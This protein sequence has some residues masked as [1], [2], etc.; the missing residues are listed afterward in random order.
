MLEM[1]RRSNNIAGPSVSVVIPTRGGPYLR[2][3]VESVIAQTKPAF[4]I[5]VVVDGAESRAHEV[6]ERLAQLGREVRTVRSRGRGANGARQTGV[7][8][9]GGSHIAFLDDDDLWVDSKLQTQC[10]L[11]DRLQLEGPMLLAGKVALF[12][13][14]GTT[15][16]FWPARAPNSREQIADYLFSHPES[17][18]ANNLQTSTWLANK[19][20]F[21]S[22]PFDDSVGLHQ[23][24]DWLVRNIR[25]DGIGLAYSKTL[26]AHY[27]IGQGSSLSAQGRLS[28]S[29]AWGCDRSIPFSKR[30]RGDFLTFRVTR[31]AFELGDWRMILRALS[32]GLRLG[33]PSFRSVLAALYRLIRLLVARRSR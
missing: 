5:L 7:Y 28:S 25:T 22:C 17:G 14:T 2:E 24:W 15:G 3:A 1:Q 27:R 13:A 8:E 18:Q 26:V 11:L 9:A 32:A 30:A 31:R 23:D 6:S 19:E 4:E 12:D 20:V 10:H 16:E 21:V 33:R 29:F